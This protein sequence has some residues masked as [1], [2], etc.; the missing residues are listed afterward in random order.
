MRNTVRWAW[1]SFE[2]LTPRQL[3]EI[4]SLRQ[5]VFI[6]EQQC[7]FPD[8]DG[9]DDQA[10]HLVGTAPDGKLVA[11]L[12]AFPP[13]SPRWPASIGRIVVRAEV[14]GSGLGKA[15]VDEGL[16]MIAERYPGAAVRIAAQRAAEAFYAKMGF[17]RE[18]DPYDE[19]G[20]PHITMVRRGE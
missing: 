11:Y 13:R 17:A 15:V 20:I 7:V 8:A 2:E 9:R 14:R 5:A 1:R 16:R 12:R 10:L 3:Y 4:L 6:V 18:G 19:D